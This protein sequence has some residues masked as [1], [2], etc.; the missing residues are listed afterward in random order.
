MAD[1]FSLTRLSPRPGA[2]AERLKVWMLPTLAVVKHEKTTDYVVGLDDLGGVE[3]FTTEA[4]VGRCVS[5]VCVVHAPSGGA[6]PGAG[7]GACVALHGR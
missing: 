3:D 6:A 7:V 5:R 4:L 2:R 1:S